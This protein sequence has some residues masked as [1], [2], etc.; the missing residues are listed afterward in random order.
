M[1]FS[2]KF[3][4]NAS[5]S[6]KK[7]TSVHVDIQSFTVHCR[8]T[9]EWRDEKY[10][11]EHTPIVAREIVFVCHKFKKYSSITFIWLPSPVVFSVPIHSILY[12]QPLAAS[13]R[14]HT[15]K[16]WGSN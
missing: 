15:K 3:L 4:C 2:S 12:S 16:E 14:T 10:G 5:F 8:V 6:G 11:A 13:R 1:F 7:Y 9:L